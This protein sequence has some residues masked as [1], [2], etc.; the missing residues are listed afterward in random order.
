MNRYFEEWWYEKGSGIT[1]KKNDGMESFAKR[2]A[3]I[4][5][6]DAWDFVEKY[7]VEENK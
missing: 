5:Y 4:A 7:P 2:I 3:E 1:P 6:K